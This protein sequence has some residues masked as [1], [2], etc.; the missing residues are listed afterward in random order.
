MAGAYGATSSLLVISPYTSEMSET[1]T[2]AAQ[3]SHTRVDLV[4]PVRAARVSMAFE[5]TGTVG[6]YC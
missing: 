2:H 5:L 3:Q 4:T 6:P 1:L